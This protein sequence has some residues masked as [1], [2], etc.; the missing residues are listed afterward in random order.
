LSKKSSKKLKKAQNGKIS[1]FLSVI[2][3]IVSSCLLL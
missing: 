1:V 3:E 2:L